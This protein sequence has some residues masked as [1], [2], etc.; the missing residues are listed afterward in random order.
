MHNKIKQ[1]R[2]ER[3]LS[4]QKLAELCG[5]SRETICRIEAGHCN[6][7]LELAFHIAAHLG[8]PIEDIFIFD[9]DPILQ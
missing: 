4:Q 5:V 7:S 6:P 8:A 2:F 1:F 3:N 9:F